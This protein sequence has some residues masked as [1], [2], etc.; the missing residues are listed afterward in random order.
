MQYGAVAGDAPQYLGLG[1]RLRTFMPLSCKFIN[2]SSLNP[3]M[4][5]ADQAPSDNLIDTILSSEF[6]PTSLDGLPREKRVKYEFEM[7][8]RNKHLEKL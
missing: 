7:K 4:A 3:S 6:N 8:S 1:A 2:G 5:L